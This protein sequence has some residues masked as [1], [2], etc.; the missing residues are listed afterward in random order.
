[1][2]P[3]L[4]R[5]T[6]GRA[7][8]GPAGAPLVIEVPPGLQGIFDD[9]WQRPIPSEGEIEGRRWSGDVGLPGPDK[10]RNTLPHIPMLMESSFPVT[11]PTKLHLNPELPAA[12]FRSVTVFDPLTGSGLDNGQLFPPLNTMD[13]PVQNTDG[14]IDIYFG[15]NS[16]GTGKNWIATLPDQG[17]FTLLRLYGP[18]K[19]FF[20]QSWRPDDIVK[21]E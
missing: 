11:V 9:S 12:I 15:S 21:T 17:W 20:D 13:K 7:P 6:E 18:T 3:G 1:M 14:S 16:L 5:V 4:F 2:L 8:F 10:A 19:A